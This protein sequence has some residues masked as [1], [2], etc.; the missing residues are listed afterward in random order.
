M[1]NFTRDFASRS[2]KI[3]NYNRKQKHSS[4]QFLGLIFMS[5]LW[6]VIAVQIIIE[7]TS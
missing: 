4:S 7:A 5:L 2:V 3:D 6:G 1:S